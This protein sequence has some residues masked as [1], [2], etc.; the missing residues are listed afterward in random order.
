MTPQELLSIGPAPN[1]QLKAVL[2]TSFEPPDRQFLVDRLFPA[3][4]GQAPASADNTKEFIR[5]RA[6]LCDALSRLRGRVVVVSSCRDDNELPWLSSYVRFHRTDTTH[7]AKLWML[8]WHHASGAERLELVVSSANLNPAGIFDQ[9][10]GA[11]RVSVQMGTSNKEKTQSWSDLP[12][13]LEQ[14]NKSIGPNDSVKQFL[15]LL[16]RANCPPG[17]AFVST[18]PAKRS[19]CGTASLRKALEKLS[20]T[21]QQ[22]RILTPFTGAWTY[23]E[24][25]EWLTAS[26]AAEV[27]RLEL[28]AIE[29]DST[30]PEKGQWL[31][32]ETTVD[33]LW[34][35]PAGDDLDPGVV[36]GLISD[37]VSHTLR[38]GVSATEDP[39]WTHAKLYEFRNGK[40]KALLV[41]SANF[42]QAAWDEKGN[43]NFELG[44]LING[45]AL[46]FEMEPAAR[47]GQV[48]A[49]GSPM[50]DGTGLWGSAE[51]DGNNITVFVTNT[52]GIEVMLKGTGPQHISIEQGWQ[53]IVI[54]HRLAPPSIATISLKGHRIQVPVIDVRP[55][56]EAL[57]IGDVREDAWQDWHDQLLLERYGYAPDPRDPPLDTKPGA[58]RCK[59]GVG[60]DYSVS[61]LAEARRYFNY[62]DGWQD[63]FDNGSY[64]QQVVTDGLKLLS[65]LKR[66]RVRFKAA[67]QVM[68]AVIE[69]FMLRLHR[70]GIGY[71]NV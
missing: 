27:T 42:T 9:I 45:A 54:A 10:Q 26:G 61:I 65:V 58:S 20:L 15:Q 70:A 38:G 63:E 46:P 25:Q 35:Q 44:V 2:L 22:V 24:I 7:H 62:V 3:L 64:R 36:F 37:N 30:V 18:V 6:E 39:R 56:P 66:H 12:S 8:H 52:P 69:E 14:L 53:K 13:Y 31:I 34:G 28:T 60:D 16:S 19:G 43:G 23:T 41:T 49:G 21:P 48:W 32:P 57:P 55:A 17:V 59:G 71:D 11:W 50:M 29:R 68:D 5:A 51:W 67:P 4:L 1:E 40:S 33:N 47:R